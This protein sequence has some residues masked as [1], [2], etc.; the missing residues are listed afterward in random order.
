MSCKSCLFTFPE[1]LD[2]TSCINILIDFGG[3][4]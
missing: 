3:A 1:W 2:H 4:F